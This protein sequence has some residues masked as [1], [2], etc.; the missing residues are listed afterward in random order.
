VRGGGGRGGAGRVAAAAVV[1]EI[2]AG[3]WGLVGEHDVRE[4]V[5][6]VTE[7]GAWAVRWDRG[8]LRVAERQ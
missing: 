2:A 5:D 8:E 6:G 7:C 1:A 3:V 4:W